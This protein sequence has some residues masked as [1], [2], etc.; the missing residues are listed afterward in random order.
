MLNQLQHK[1]FMLATA[2]SKMRDEQL[3][4]AEY[5]WCMATHSS[6]VPIGDRNNNKQE[7][8]ESVFT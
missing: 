8:P 4:I 7:R 5:Y 3:S 6:I 2:V 1:R